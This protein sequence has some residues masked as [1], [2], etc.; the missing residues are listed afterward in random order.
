[1]TCGYPADKLGWAV[2]GGTR[3]NLQ[4]GDY[5]QWQATY[6]QGAIRYVGFTP[7]GAFSPLLFNRHDLGYG[8]LSR[9]VYSHARQGSPRA[10]SWG[11][12]AAYDHLWTPQFRTSIYGSY[13]RTEYGSQANR[14]ICQAQSTANIGASPAA[15]PSI[16]GGAIA[17]TQ[18]QIDQGVCNNNFNFWTV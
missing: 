9:A 2:G 6:T 7:A 10:T 18:A 14:A 4:G 12:N 17:F 5:F 3:F 13:W 8:F 11:I 15:N 16:V 1:E